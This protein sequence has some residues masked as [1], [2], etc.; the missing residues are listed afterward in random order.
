VIAIGAFAA[1]ALCASSAFAGTEDILYSFHPQ[2]NGQLPG[3][4]LISDS[5][6]HLY[7]VTQN[8]GAYNNGTVYMLSPNAHNGWTETVL[9]SFK[10]SVG[11]A[12]DGYNPVGAL[13][14]DSAGNLYGAT[15]WGGNGKAQVGTVFKLT[16]S[17]GKWNETIVWSFQQSNSKDGFNPQGGLIFDKA[18][19]LYGTT[20][21][22][23]GYT[24]VNCSFDGGCGTVFQLRPQAGGQWNESIL[25]VF[26]GH[27]DGGYPNDS[28]V[29][30]SSGNLYGTS[31]GSATFTGVVFEVSPEKNG[32]WT[33]ATLYNF[34][35]D[36]PGLGPSGGLIF[37]QAGNLDGVTYGG[38]EC[39][40]CGTVF[41]LVA[42]SNGKW[43]EKTLFDFNGSDGEEPSGKLL[44]DQQGNL[45][46]TT[47]AG[48]TGGIT[49]G[50]GVVFELTPSSGGQYGESVLWNFTG[51]NDGETPSYGVIAGPGGVLYGT[52]SN[53]PI[54]GVVF[55][56]AASQ[57]KWN[58]TTLESF[59]PA[60][61]GIPQAALVADAA[62][63]LYG[64]TSEDGA[65]GYGTVFKLTKSATSWTETILYDFPRGAP[66]GPYKISNPSILI[67][68]SAGNLYGETEYGGSADWGM[69]YELSPTAKGQWTEKT[70]FT[71]KGTKTG[72]YPVGGLVFDSEGNLYGATNLGGLDSGN[73]F[74]D[75]GLV[76]ELTPTQGEWKETV[77]YNFLGGNDGAYP[78]GGVIFDKAGNLYGTTSSGALRG[79][80]CAGC[81]TVFKLTHNSGGIWT[82][83]LLH[84][85]SDTQGDGGAPAAGVI[86]DEAGNLYGT[87]SLGGAHGICNTIGCG[88]VFE[89]SPQSGAWRE[90]ILYTFL[91]S[92]ATTPLAGV[93][94]DQ[95]GN[96]Y[97]TTEGGLYGDWGS[98]FE[99]SPA[100][101]GGWNE[102]SLY[103]F[104]SVGGGDG[105]F[106]EAAV[107][108]GPSGVLYG[109]TAGGGQG[110]G[111]TVFQ[112]TP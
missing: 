12:A 84:Q 85:F 80:A 13:T 29:M 28:L 103:T 76:F 79:I 55:Q 67:F 36:S 8:G 73:C 44:L 110:N 7:G 75:C 66:I 30:D 58:E 90:S 18:G 41:Q 82:E 56:L 16:K 104:P 98:V 17:N 59:Q 15:T 19:N 10:G 21:F 40:G 81:G 94:F 92:D 42:G 109:T 111:G 3:G 51:G 24:N 38:G 32:G 47:V 60:D 52:N 57:G 61:G 39:E 6:G 100:S 14:F 77:L 101:G 72:L 70:L 112:I 31:S 54:A 23:G 4:G 97:G 86:F 89:L 2:L 25:Y 43:S 1:V 34:T 108:L 27:S 74:Q 48:G 64:V 87:T 50:K 91:G 71:F 96:L 20:R 107:V 95:A 106:P 88:I 62:G 69:V 49:D 83:S 37:D 105:Y 22:G 46:G 11:G 53:A 35:G 99:L 68:D 65:Y 5:A 9:Y 93:T 45:Y 78:L 102:I 63:D 33:E 26:Q